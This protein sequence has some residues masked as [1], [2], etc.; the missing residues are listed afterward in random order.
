MDLTPSATDG[1]GVRSRDG[2][3]RKR[4]FRDSST[5]RSHVVGHCRSTKGL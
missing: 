1:V 3:A 2:V 4:P 5:R